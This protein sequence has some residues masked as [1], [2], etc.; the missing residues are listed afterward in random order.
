[1]SPASAD[2]IAGAA[3][4]GIAVGFLVVWTVSNVLRWARADVDRMVCEALDEDD[5]GPLAMYGPVD[6]EAP[7]YAELA[8]ER[9]RADLDAWGA[10]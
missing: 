9:L 3:L 7:I 5:W 6:N 1:M 8:V 4:V 10:S 2:H